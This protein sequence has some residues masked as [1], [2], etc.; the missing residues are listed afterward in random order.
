MR[1]TVVGCGDA[2]GSGGRANTCFWLETHGTTVALDFGATSLVAL[3]RLGLDP[4]RLDG[5]ILSHLHGDH[6]GGLP[7][8]LLDAHFS[9]RGGKP[10]TIIGPVG[11]AKRLEAALEVF[12][13]G[14]SK[15]EWRFPLHVVDLPCRTPHRFAELD[16]FTTEVVHPSGAPSTAVRLRDATSILVYSGDTSWTEALVDIAQGAH[17][18][19]IECYRLSGAPPAHL[20]L[21]TIDTHRARFNAKRVMLTHMSAPVLDKLAEIE[22]RDYL[23]AYDGLTIEI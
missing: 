19:I 23:A 15:N 2:F 6:F 16:V 5:V 21:E 20:D 22:A 1:L 17:L 9:D 18:C 7:F 10:L 3:K 4:R 13:T 14:A 12:F 8:L 11:T